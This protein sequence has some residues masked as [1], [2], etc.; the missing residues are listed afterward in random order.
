MGQYS[1]EGYSYHEESIVYGITGENMCFQH[2][3][4]NALDLVSAGAEV[5]IIFEGP[6]VKLVSVFE[7]E[8]NQL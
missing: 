6:S 8:K 7:E 2:I 5:K 3:F 1:R 4:L